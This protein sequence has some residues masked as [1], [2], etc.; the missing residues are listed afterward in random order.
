MCVLLNKIGI[1]TKYENV[2]ILSL[3]DVP[4]ALHKKLDCWPVGHLP[5]PHVRILFFTHFKVNT[6]VTISHFADFGDNLVNLIFSVQ[7][8]VLLGMWH[9]SS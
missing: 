2:I 8:S 7:L 1:V 9:Q 6:V 3:E 4:T 5:K